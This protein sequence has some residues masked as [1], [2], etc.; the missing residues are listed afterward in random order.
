MSI[1]RF[2]GTHRTWEDWCGMALGVMILLSPWFTTRPD[3]NEVIVNALCVGILVFGLSQLEYLALQRWE[4]AGALALGF[5]LIASPFIFNYAGA[6]ALR[7]WH[8]VLGG[9]VA[10]L[11]LLQLWQDWLRSD[12]ELARHNK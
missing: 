12:Q 11:A 1:T 7:Y 5:W 4:E 8:F 2:F 3:H 9:L 10:A 6:D